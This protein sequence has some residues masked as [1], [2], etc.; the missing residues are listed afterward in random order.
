GIEISPSDKVPRDSYERET[1]LAAL[2]EI[3][4]DGGDGA[5]IAGISLDFGG[6]PGTTDGGNGHEA[7]E[8]TEIPEVDSPSD[9]S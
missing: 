8:A 9:E 4:A 3:G 1:L 7:G 5:S 6:Q 2:Q